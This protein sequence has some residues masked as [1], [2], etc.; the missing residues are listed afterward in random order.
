MSNRESDGAEHTAR[1]TH[2]NPATLEPSEQHVRSE[3]EKPGA[4]FIQNVENNGIV[5]PPIGRVEGDELRLIDGVRRAKAADA[6]GIGEI[7]VLIRDLDDTEAKIQSLTLNDSTAGVEKQVADVDRDA[8]LSKV[9]EYTGEERIETER[10]LGMLSDA[11]L[12]EREMEPIPGVGRKTAEKIAE[13]HTYQELKDE[14]NAAGE[15]RAYPIILKNID[16]V[17]EKTARAIWRQFEGGG[18]GE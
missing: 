15:I 18:S 14:A 12:I 2:A 7:P 5:V 8:S 17:G 13:E 9:Q 10:R 16:G 11:D 4:G 6:A 1:T 3:H